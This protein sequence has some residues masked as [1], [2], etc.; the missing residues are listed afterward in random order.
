MGDKSPWSHRQTHL[1]DSC[2]AL[3]A[4]AEHVIGKFH[5]G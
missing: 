2:L 5:Q 1:S 4:Q 3:L